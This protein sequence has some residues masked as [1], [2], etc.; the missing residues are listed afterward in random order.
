MYHND[1]VAARFGDIGDLQIYHSGNDSYIQDGGTGNLLI[2]SNGAS[3]QINKGTTENMAEFIVDGPVRL[4]DDS[5]KKLETRIVGVGTA[6][7][8]GGTLIDG[9]KTTTQANAINDTTIATT[10]YVNNKIGLIPAGLQFEGTWDAS[11]GNPPS[12][13]PENGQFWIV[14]VA[15]STSLSGITDWK[16]GDWAIYVV[17]G[18]GTDGWQKARQFICIRWIWYRAICN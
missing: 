6:T 14:S 18:S 16:V 17:A 12:A 2:T 3:V 10:A 9:W 13:S 4:Y 15:G 11:T 8:A 5:N 1:G 7:T